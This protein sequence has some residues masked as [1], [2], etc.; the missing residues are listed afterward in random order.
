MFRKDQA[1]RPWIWIEVVEPAIDFCVWV[2]LADG[3]RV[4]PF[5]LHSGGSGGLRAVGLDESTWREWFER[6]VAAQRALSQQVQGA[7]DLSKLTEREASSLVSHLERA[8]PPSAWNGPEAVRES[9]AR[10]W[11][12]YE[13]EGEAWRQQASGSSRQAGLTPRDRHNIWQKL[14]R[15]RERGEALTVFLVRYPQPV[16]DIAPPAALIVGLGRER[17]P[18]GY[19]RLLREGVTRLDRASPRTR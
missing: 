14:S 13:P 19:L 16:V 12:D 6:V 17:G 2:L 7:G 11:V 8:Q 3:L 1:T 10:L 9:L 15:E 5:N 18:G 4:P